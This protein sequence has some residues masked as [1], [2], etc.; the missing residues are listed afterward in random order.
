MDAVSRCWAAGRQNWKGVRMRMG[1]NEE[2]VT[3]QPH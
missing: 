1:S 2:N 3:K